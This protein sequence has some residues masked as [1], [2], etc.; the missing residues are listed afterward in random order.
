MIVSMRIRRPSPVVR[1]VMELTCRTVR[2]VR[3]R[4]PAASRRGEALQPGEV[5]VERPR[6][7]AVGPAGVERVLAAAAV[8]AGAHVAVVGAA[9]GDL[10]VL[11][12]VPAAAVALQAAGRGAA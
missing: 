8:A 10:A 6:V 5:G 2:P 11:D 1:Y 3:I 4:G 9:V 7:A 12:D